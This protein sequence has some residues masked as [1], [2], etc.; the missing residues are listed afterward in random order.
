MSMFADIILNDIMV[1]PGKSLCFDRRKLLLVMFCETGPI[2]G[3]ICRYYI[4]Y[5]TTIKV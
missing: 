5:E 1:L 2:V 4:M 3:G